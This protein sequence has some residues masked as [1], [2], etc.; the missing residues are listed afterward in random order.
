M[1]HGPPTLPPTRVS[2]AVRCPASA[3][4]SIKTSPSPLPSWIA[5]GQLTNTEKFNPSSGTSPNA[6]FST[7][8]LHPPSHLPVVGGALKLQGQPQLQLHATRNFPFRYQ[9]FAISH[10]VW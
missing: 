7:C 6:P 2:I 1:P 3:R 9:L 10:L 4:S 5:P 8:Q